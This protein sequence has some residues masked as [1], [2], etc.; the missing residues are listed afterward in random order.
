MKYLLDTHTFIWM[1]ASPDKLSNKV[2]E[3]VSQPENELLLCAASGWETALLWK[4]HKIELSEEPAL[5]I[6]QMIQALSLTPVAISFDLAITAACLPLHHRDP[7]DRL[8]IAVA[9]QEKIALLSKDRMMEK[10]KIQ[11]IW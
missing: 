5:F 10:Y 7:F 3:L 2:I 6:P 8:L 9:M 1:A 4:L 11:A